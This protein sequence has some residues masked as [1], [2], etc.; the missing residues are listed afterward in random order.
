LFADFLHQH[1]LDRDPKSIPEL[2][3]HAS[4]WFEENNLFPEAIN[5]SLLAGDYERAAKLV[6]IIGP[7]MMMQSEFDQL[8]KWLDAMPKE[9]VEN[10]PWLCI[11]RAWMYDR[12][13][14]FEL[15][16][17]YLQYAETAV[18][19]KPSLA[20][21][22]DDKIIRGQIS[23]IRALYSLKKGQIPESIEF[24]N[25]ALDYLPKDY[26]NR[27][28][29][30]FSLGWAK[31]AQGDLSGAIQAY[32]EG[33]RAS[34]AAGNQILAQVIILDIGKTQSLQGHLH[35]AAETFREAIGFK[36]EKSEIKIPYASSA[37]IS[38]ANI[39]R[40][41]NELDAAMSHLEEGIEIGLASKI[42]DAVAVGYA[43]MVLVALAQDDLEA[44]IQACKKTERMVKDIPDLETDTLTKTL[45][46][47]VRL[48][49][50]QNKLTE[51]ARYIQER[52]LSADTKIKY[53][54]DFE[55]IV[56][57][58]LL[59]HLGR[60]NS[61]PQDLSDAH[62][63]LEEIFQMAS[64][65][66]YVSLSIEALALQA[67][68]LDVQGKHSQAL[69]SLEEALSLAEPEGYVRTF[70]DEGEP[71]KGLLRQA[72]SRGIA[73]EYV[74]R[75]LAEFE[76]GSVK[77]HPLTQPLVE[78]LTGREIQVLKL[79]ATEL[80]GSEI[81]DELMVSLNTMRTHSKSIYS[82]LAV[83]NRRAAISKAMDL[84]LL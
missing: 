84:N 13:A 18:N 48:S 50:S 66:G 19:S 52:G 11:I 56:L 82:K 28:V 51:A 55:H 60:L 57:A 78:P 20:S 15:G 81:A 41:W 27:G 63:L 76:P 24:S 44:A 83:S 47:Q 72:A 3:R 45:D 16:E 29:A 23:A 62:K 17:Q 65:V 75:L 35:Q 61:A 40:E 22:E 21:E 33:H 64:S 5:H 58:R 71:M 68:A 46:S 54:A 67:L 9:L 36:Y 38:L 12:W 32:D 79:L 73:K 30:Y 42:V 6:E 34:L 25:H 77:G 74:V 43:S 26:F 37:S 2:H 1:L 8:S 49:I 14:Q 69:N 4:S 10:W 80:T 31:S 70:I 39:L 59:V 53:I 7:D